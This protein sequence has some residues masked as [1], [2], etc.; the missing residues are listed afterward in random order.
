LSGDAAQ[1]VGVCGG[2]A[3][4]FHK[5]VDQTIKGSAG[6]DERVGMDFDEKPFGASGR[7]TRA[8]EH[9]AGEWFIFVES[10]PE[11]DVC[12]SFDAVDA[13]FAI[14]LGRV[15]VASGKKST[16][17]E[18]REVE[19][20]ADDEVAHV[21]IA[22]KDTGRTGAKFTFLGRC[23][24]HDSAKRGERHHGRRKG[25]GNRVFE[26]PDVEKR[27]GKSVGQKAEPLD[28]TGPTPA[29]EGDVE[30]VDLERVA[31]LSVTHKNGP[32][33]GMNLRAI[34]LEKIGDGGGGG[35]LAAAG[36]VALEFHRVARSDLQSRS[37]STVPDVVGVGFS[38]EMGG[39]REEVVKFFGCEVVKF[40]KIES[41]I[42]SW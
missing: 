27:L 9:G 12:G 5:K 22:T 20:G 33:K 1:N 21:H 35:Y 30:H 18:D 11:S 8:A 38:E 4:A 23:D 34:D 6:R 40:F 26:G 32:G 15:D 31:G 19:S 28:H 2:E 41:P 24:A 3:V 14:A 17:S 39:H 36:V 37:Q 25:T 7:A 10:E 42:F 13:D 29:V 16:G